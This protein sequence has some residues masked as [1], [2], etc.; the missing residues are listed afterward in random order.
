MRSP[1]QWILKD[2]VSY[3]YYNHSIRD[4]ETLMSPRR[5]M[6]PVGYSLLA[7]ASTY[8]I[9]RGRQPFQCCMDGDNDDEP[10]LRAHK[11]MPIMP[12]NAMS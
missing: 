2:H 10:G 3:N 9:C 4:L 7:F 1:L 12:V 8:L 5:G 11:T 6:E